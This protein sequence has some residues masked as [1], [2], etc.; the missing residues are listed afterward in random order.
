V[1][2]V[3]QGYSP[4]IGGTELLIQKVSEKLVARHGDQVTVYT[5]TAARNCEVFVNPL[6][7]QL[8]PG[9]EVIN[10]VT[11]R[12]F[13][14]FNWFGPALFYVARI[15]TALR[16]PRNDYLRALFM[17][18]IVRGMTGE[19]A[20]APVD[21]V[22]ASS[23]PLMHMQYV[24][25]ARRQ[26]GVPTVLH[27]GLHPESPWSFDLGIIYAAIREADAYICNTTYERDHLLA[28][29]IDAAKM[30]TIGVGV[31]PEQFAAANGRAIRERYRLGD[32]PVV[33]FIGQQVEHKGVDHLVMAMPSVWRA[34]PTA[35]LLI[36]G[37]R[38]RFS[39]VI[40]WRISQL[41]PEQ[42]RRVTIIDDFPEADKP[43]L[44]D[45]CDVF[46]YPSALESFGIA[47]L[48]AWIRGKPVI[49]CRAG[50]VPSVIDDGSDGIL[51]RVKDREDLA[52]AIITL[53]DSAALRLEMGQRGREKTLSRYTWDKVSDRF[54][55]TYVQAVQAKVARADAGAGPA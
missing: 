26:S 19:I 52:R 24:V 25:A 9:V 6:H 13:R 50:A 49:G 16:L 28:R 46:A 35:R 55:E 42:Q 30:T 11:V 51:V 37:S 18:P 31:D 29:G 8:R 1:L 27:G 15:A 43:D 17:G 7:R 23:F 10:G 33:A 38:T 21:V 44:F 22:G 36:A 39:K 2:H 47:Y 14:V 40:R 53:L 32:D 41:P 34:C 54:R 20:R 12:R 5:T 4:S 48:E 45:C 3:V